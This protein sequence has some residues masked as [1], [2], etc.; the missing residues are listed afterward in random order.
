MSYSH[1]DREQAQKIAE[2][3]RR[4]G[5]DAW[6]D[7]WEIGAGDSITQKVFEE[8]L[9]ECAVFVILLSKASTQSNWVR[10]EL[11]VAL[12]N[13][14]RRITH[15]V[16]VLVEDCEIPAALRVLLWVHINEGIDKVVQAIVNAAYKKGPEKPELQPPPKR[17]R[18]LLPGEAGLTQEATTMAIE[19]AGK[20]DLSKEFPPLFDAN[21][22]RAILAFSQEE[23][24]DA[25]NELNAHGIVKLHKAL[26]THPYNFLWL[27]PT[28]NLPYIF[29]KHLKEPFDPN[30]DIKQ[31]AAQIGSFKRATGA[32]LADR[33]RLS[34]ARI[35]LAVAYLADAGIIKMVMALGTAPFNFAYVLTTPETR[36]FVSRVSGSFL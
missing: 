11:D 12:V 26:G 1:S 33:L 24:N 8:G 19:I 5:V 13:R 25:A 10:Y 4:N 27:E 16:P 9:K 18:S 3:L 15:I 29:S 36:K 22:L 23:I 21:E 31:V 2:E 35:D 14:I 6:F 30:V 28:Y 7:K 34:P 20:L 17:I 32:E